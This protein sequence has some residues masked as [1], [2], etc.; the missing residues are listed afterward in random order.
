MSFVCFLKIRIRTLQSCSDVDKSSNGCLPWHFVQANKAAI[1]LISEHFS[2]FKDVFFPLFFEGKL[3]DFQT[4]NQNYMPETNL[5][6]RQTVHVN[7]ILVIIGTL[8]MFAFVLR[9]DSLV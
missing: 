6:V 8:H 9:F 1:L 3:F 7:L 5:R 2:S 4:G